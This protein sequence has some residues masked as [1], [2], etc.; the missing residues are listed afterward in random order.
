LREELR[1]REEE[2]RRRYEA[3]QEKLRDLIE[4]NQKIEK[5]NANFAKDYFALRIKKNEIEQSLNEENEVLRLKNTAIANKFRTH[6]KQCE[7]ESKVAKELIEKKSEEYTNKFR[8]QIRQ[9]DENIMII[10]VWV[11]LKE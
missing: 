4:K 3:D 11:F 6:L 9:K 10:K 5:E 1:I 7:V 8:N 2:T